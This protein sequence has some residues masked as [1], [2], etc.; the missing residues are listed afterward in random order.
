MFRDGWLAEDENELREM[1]R[2]LAEI[3]LSPEFRG[4]RREL[5]KFYR[6]SGLANPARV[7]FQDALFSLLMER[8]ERLTASVQPH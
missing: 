5:E 1:A 8:E 7:A 3:C 2:K 6:Q 4:L